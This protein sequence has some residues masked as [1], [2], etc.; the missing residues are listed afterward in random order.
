VAYDYPGN[1]RELKHAVEMAATFCR[2]GTIEPWILP[3]TLQR[4]GDGSEEASAL[5]DGTIPFPDRVR[6]F[7]R[8]LLVKVLRETG[9]RKLEAAKKLGISRGTLWRRLQKHGFDAVDEWSDV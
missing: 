5:P 9:G 4:A 1:V 8:E 2:N 3:E 6:N 7:E